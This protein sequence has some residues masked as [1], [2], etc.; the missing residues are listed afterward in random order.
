M[1]AQREDFWD[2]FKDDEGDLSEAARYVE[3]NPDATVGEVLGKFDLGLDR[4]DDVAELLENV[5][6]KP[7]RVGTW[8]ADDCD[9]YGGR[10]S[11]DDRIHHFGN[12][13]IGERGWLGNPYVVEENAGEEHRHQDD[14]VLVKTREE[15]VSRFAE[16]FLDAIQERPELRRKL[17]E[18]V[19]A[20]VLGCW[21][22]ELDDDGPLCHL[23]VVA[24][25]AD[26]ITKRGGR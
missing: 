22:Q 23:E 12:T 19:R 26:R 3:R 16:D 21:C 20:R 13:P 24:E 1:S 4:T 5:E 11:V 18:D 25:V 15:A 17:Y 6:P 9:V 8:M 10:R 2:Q 14:V 7:T